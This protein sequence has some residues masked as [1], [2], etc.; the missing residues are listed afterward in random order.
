MTINILSLV[1]VFFFRNNLFNTNSQ[2]D[3]GGFRALAEAQAQVGTSTTLFAYQF[4]DAGTYVFYSSANQYKK[5][6]SLT[7]ATDKVLSFIRK[8]MISF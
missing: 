4:N 5:I 6:V 2:F 1:L 7:I 8:M 3:Y